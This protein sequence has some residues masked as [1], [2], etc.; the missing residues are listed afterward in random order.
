MMPMKNN[1]KVLFLASEADPFVKIGGLGDVAGSLPPALFALGGV[2]IRLALPFHGGIHRQ[3]YHLKPVATFD[4][5]HTG[6]PIRAEVLE[7]SLN[8][9]TVYLVSGEP[10]YPDAPVYTADTSAD[11]HKF[12]FFSLAVLELVRQLGWKPDVIHAND[13]HTAP[14]IYALS[15]MNDSF[16]DNTA[17]VFG[18]H[19]LPYLGN[20]AGP[21]MNAFGLPPAAGS[22]LPLWAQ[23]MPMPLALLT[24]DQ[25]VAAS[26]NYAREILTPE[27]G[28]GLQDFLQTR[29]ETISGILNG[30]NTIRWDPATDTALKA[31][32]ALDRLADRQANRAA[33][34]DEFGLVPDPDIPLLAMVTR[35]DPQKG[36]DLLPETIAQIAALPW[37]LV[38]LG[39]GMPAT[40]EIARQVEAAYPE[41]VRAA[42]RFDAMLS[43]RMYAGADMLLIPSRYEPCGLTQMIAMRYGCVPVARATGGLKDT[44]RDAADGEH[45]SGFLFTSAS[46][47]DFA[48]ALSRAI[49]YYQKRSAWQKLQMNGMVQDFSWE[50]FARQYLELYRRLA[51]A[52]QTK[53]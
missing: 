32:Y 47:E 29:Q 34:L 53:K 14:A 13:W 27:F 38:I 45:G 4:V 49:G 42:I 26:P 24:A 40:E 20:E 10:I 8:G 15:L 46:P 17:T 9:M 43:H 5:L 2:D 51:K 48:G 23:N 50:R 31:S 30:I 22:A 7:T 19:N 35:M 28:S 1:F 3:S 39:M 36:V 41:R 44:I 6:G 21:A 16:F 25:I 12:T 37:Q 52:R 33:L 18:L 11:G